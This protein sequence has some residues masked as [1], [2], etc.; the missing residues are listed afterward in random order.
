MTSAATTVIAYYCS[1]ADHLMTVILSASE[2]S[3]HRMPFLMRCR[4]FSSAQMLHF[5]QHDNL[6]I[7]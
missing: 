3:G 5:V 7:R 1:V 4:L 6:Q 2:G